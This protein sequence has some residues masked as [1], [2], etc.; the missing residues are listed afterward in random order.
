[1]S[2]RAHGEGTITQRK[3]GRLAGFWEGAVTTPEGRKH[4]YAR[5]QQECRQ[6]VKQLLRNLEQ[7]LPVAP[8]RQSVAQ[9]LEKWLEDVAKVTV[10]PNVYVRYRINV[11]RHLIPAIGKKQLT[12]LT[13]QDL[14]RVY[15]RKLQDGLAP[16][17][18]HQMHT[19]LHNAL[20]HA[21]KWGLVGRNVS[22]IATPPRVPR[23]DIKPLS[24]G[25]VRQLLSAV[26]DDHWLDSLCTL[27]VTTGLRLAEVLGLRWGDVDMTAGTLRVRRQIQR[28][29]GLGLIELEPKSATSRR[30]IRLTPVGVAAL[31]RQRVRTMEMRLAAGDRWDE[32]DLVFPNSLGRPKEAR[33]IEKRFV[34]LLAKAGLP[35]VR[36]H[37]LRHSAATLLFSLG[38]HPKVVQ[39][40]L[41]HSGIGITMNLYTHHMPV[42]H[43]EAMANL[44][45]LLAEQ[46]PQTLTQL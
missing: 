27:T 31:K 8:K 29:A 45:Q 41:G 10:R 3:T 37:D 16:R 1:M 30:L 46:Q 21:V 6:K 44:G 43:D 28:V 4:V 15:A 9:F 23:S 33:A 35:R 39:E 36:F 17:T 13:P 11:H 24:A 40:I 22:D 32:H 2:K 19:V 5:T 25:E 20:G 18:V 14:Q 42:L 34:D 7:G 26:R 12:A 38:T